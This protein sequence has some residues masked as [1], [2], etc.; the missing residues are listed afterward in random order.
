MPAVVRVSWYGASATEPAGVTAESGV[1]L[2]RSD[3]QQG[4]E[5]VLLP[6]TT[7]GTSYS[8]IKQVALEVLTTAATTLSNGSVRATAVMPPGIAWMYKASD[9]YQGT[10]GGPPASLEESGS[11]PAVPSGFAVP[12]TSPAVYSTLGMSTGTTGR[13][14]PFVQLVGG[15]SREYARLWAAHGIVKLPSLVMSYDET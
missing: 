5:P 8:F 13:K 7:P 2:D 14:G 4:S 9:T 6:T 3:S 11:N 1:S 12:T 15:L 10:A